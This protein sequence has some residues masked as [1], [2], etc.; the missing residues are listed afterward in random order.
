MKNTALI[1][2]VSGG[3]GGE[4]ARQ[5]RDAGWKVRVMQRG[6]S[7]PITKDGMDWVPGDAMQAGDVLKAAKGCEVIV[8]AVNPP[9]YRKWG[10][11]VLPM[12]DNSIAAAKAHGALILLPGTLY[13][14]GPDVF[15]L[16]KED[17]PQN[18]L[19]QKGKIRVELERRLA[20]A[21]AT[22]QARVLIVRAGD[23]FGPQ[24]RN[25][26]LSQGMIKP[27]QPIKSVSLP[28]AA[29]VGHQYA[30]VPDVARTMVELLKRR[31]QLPA[32]ASYQMQGHWDADGQQLGLAIQ[33]VVTRYGG[34]KPKLAAFPWWSIYL[35]APFVETMRELL[36]MRYIW[37][38]E[39][40]LD[41]QQLLK[42]LGT[43]PHTP[44]EQALEITLQGLGCLPST[45]VS[46]PAPVHAS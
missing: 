30:Y 37:Q 13:N 25:S 4:V 16:V 18:A 36:K 31:E 17:A 23:F 8:H 3:V 1:L 44:L 34:A 20:Q 14:F 15:P 28:A 10:T 5:L 33:K 45:T 22:G 39:I 26:W 27:G 32:F 38:Q 7:S 43:E 40:R 46:Q 21:A 6:L 2:G 35:I 12:I 29:G 41:N 11:Y 42:I 19:T 9:G 24:V